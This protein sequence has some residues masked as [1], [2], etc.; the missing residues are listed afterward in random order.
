MTPR[1]ATLREESFKAQPGI[2]VERAVLVT[3]FYRKN[4]GKYSLPVLRALNFKNLCQK[5]LTLPAN[6][7]RRINTIHN[8]EEFFP[9]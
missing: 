6:H 9:F 4:Y 2:S 7:V 3:R 5:F 8:S 1:V